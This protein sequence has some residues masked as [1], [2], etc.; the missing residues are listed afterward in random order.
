MNKLTHYLLRTF[1]TE[2]SLLKKVYKYEEIPKEV[3]KGCPAC[4]S[5]ELQ[6]FCNMDRYG[7]NV[8][9]S[10]CSF[11]GL[12]FVN[13]RINIEYYNKFYMDGS[14]RRIIDVVS[15]KKPKSLN[16]IP[17]RLIVILSKLTEIYKNKEINVLDIGGTAGV[18]NYLNENLNIKEYLCVN[19]GADEADISVSSN[20]KVVNTTIEEYKADDKKYD[21]IILFG[22]ISHLMD[23][24][25]AFLKSRKLLR[26]DGLFVLDFK[27]SLDRMQS[28]KFTFSQLHFDHPIY[29]SKASLES[30]VSRVGLIVKEDIKYNSGVSY[31][32]LGVNEL[33][34]KQEDH[35]VDT[36]K[37]AIEASRCQEVSI[38]KILFKRLV[39]K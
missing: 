5:K 36:D 30:L 8:H 10:W 21:L 29:L 6:D 4:N 22:T 31:Y 3:L 12:I 33:L 24:Y 26:D 11:C 13:P 39:S 32:F 34:T 37:V 25:S 1:R 7:F 9:T 19:P 27:D 15:K 38:L 2:Y 14:Y 20:V 18:Y 35:K 28:S 17:K 23:P 16:V